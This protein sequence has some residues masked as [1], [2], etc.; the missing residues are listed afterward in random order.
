MK[1]LN[2]RTGFAALTAALALG[3]AS[4]ANAVTVYTSSN[5]AGG[6]R[7]LTF[8]S[9]GAT[10]T[11]IE[12]RP[13]STGGL[14][15]G[16]GLGS[17][18]AL[19][20]ARN[21]RVLLAVNAGSNDVST[22]RVRR[23]GLKLIGVYPSGG[24]MPTS[25]AIHDDLVYVM[26]A[27]GE[28][29]VSGFVLENNGKLTPIPNSTRQLSSTGAAPAQVGFNQAGDALLV[30]ERATNNIRIF[31][32]ND[33]GLLGEPVD[34]ASSGQTPF[35]FTFDRRDNLLV[36]EAFGGAQNQAA[37]SSYGLNID[38]LTLETVTGSASADQTAAC[39]VVTSRN[40]RY[41]YVTNTGS[42]TVTGYSV[43]RTGVLE[44]LNGDP[45]TGLTGGNPLD[46]SV[47]ANM[48]FVLTPRNGEIVPFKIGH[49]G[50]LTREPS[51]FGVST[52]AAGV[53][54]W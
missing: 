5:D 21:G 32:V 6:N 54:A 1:F 49:D 36:S 8:E 20:L 19:T 51:I 11:F 43:G 7:I 13:F 41:A 28:G 35:G 33:D 44:R 47:R 53:V 12:K 31:P 40:G 46:A 45:V 26:N 25:V 16:G 14:G 10:G 23:N 42:G 22:F 30:T 15:S 27:G 24:V 3:A 2:L 39:W 48:M 29:N 4:T 37:L 34:N 38:D 9:K 17:Q 18:D 50:S 52:T